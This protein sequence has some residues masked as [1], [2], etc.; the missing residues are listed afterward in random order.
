MP[1]GAERYGSERLELTVVGNGKAR[2]IAQHD[3]ARP[4]AY[5]RLTLD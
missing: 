3:R 4:P 1:G 2:G 5:F